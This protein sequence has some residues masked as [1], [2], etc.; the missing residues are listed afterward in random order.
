MSCAPRH[1]R[2]LAL[3]LLASCLLAVPATAAPGLGWN[4][5]PTATE[6]PPG[7]AL[8]PPT[9]AETAAPQPTGA[10]PSAEVVPLPAGETVLEVVPEPPPIKLWCASFELGLN[11]SEGNSDLFNFRFGADAKRETA[12][13]ILK[14]DLDYK[15]DTTED[16]ETANRL[17]FDARHEWLFGE[18]P[19]TVFVHH[20]DEYD[21]F[22]AFDLRITF[23]AGVGYYFIKREGTS[24]QGRA[25][26]GV[27]HEIGGPDDDWVPEAVLG[28]TLEHQLT[29]RQKLCATADYYPSWEDF[30]DFRAVTAVNWEILLDEAWHLSLKLGINDRYDS[31]P[32]GAEH[33]DLDYSAVLLWSY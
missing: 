2:T 30:E 31:T 29:A 10:P 7:P 15:K 8:A 11:G 5:F 18:S 32:D 24:L 3:A 19:W 6:P 21:E 16:V 14:F 22:K 23:D 28:A 25:G 20:T 12:A 4:L 27:S 17:F 9:P 1:R 33:N 26:S 13:S